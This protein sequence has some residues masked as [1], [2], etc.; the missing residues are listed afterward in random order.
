LPC[1]RSGAGQRLFDRADLDA[2][3]GRPAT[4]GDAEGR[5]RVEALCCRVSGSTGQ[6]S[7][8]ANQEQMLR[9]SSSG[10]VFRVYRDRGSGLRESRRGLDRPLDDAAEGRFTVVRV[11]WRD[12][13]SALRGGL[14]RTLLVGVWR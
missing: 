7:S 9:D 10:T 2:C 14:D 5:E 11:V 6:E 4:G 13:F 8:L 3:L 1:R 12:R